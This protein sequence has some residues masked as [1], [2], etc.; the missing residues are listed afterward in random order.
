MEEIKIKFN[1]VKKQV[2]ENNELTGYLADGMSIPL[3]ESNRHYK[4]VLQ[5]IEE[6]GI[7]EEAYTPEELEAMR[8]AEE[9]RLAKTAKTKALDELIITHNTVAYDANGK[10]IGN[11]AAVMGVANF[12][13]NQLV[14]IGALDTV[15]GDYIP[16]SP[17]DAYTFVY[18]TSKIWW[19]GADDKPHEVMIESVCEALE[20]SMLEVAAIIGV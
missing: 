2:N 20:K 10:A 18:K 8:L 3:V 1:S 13:Y 9:V 7:V 15:T 17:L 16:M 14:S 4:M 5:W 19:K 12:K 6:G 11:M